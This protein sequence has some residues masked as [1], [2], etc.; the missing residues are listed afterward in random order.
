MHTITKLVI[1]LIIPQAAGLVGALFTTPAID[2]WYANLIKSD[3]APPN[4]VFGPVWTILFLMMGVAL[5]LVWSR[6]TEETAKDKKKIIQIALVAFGIQ[7]VLNVLWSVLFFGSPSL[8]LWG[9][10]NIGVAF[11]EI[12]VLW[13]A[14]MVTI[15]T[16]NAVSKPAALLLVPY[17]LWVSFAGYLNYTIWQ[18]N[19][20]QP[21]ACTLEAMMCPDGSY[22]GRSGPNCEFICP[23]EV[24]CEEGVLCQ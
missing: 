21:V 17:I 9:M 13:V 3:L 2:G 4:W 16:F 10:N 7:M 24:V 6:Y 11:I 1:A 8:M 5:F 15:I 12:I 19:S 20:N 22:V 18:L 23:S 14:I